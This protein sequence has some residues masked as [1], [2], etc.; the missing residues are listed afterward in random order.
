VAVGVKAGSH[1]HA[2]IMESKA[3]ALNM[4]GKGQQAMAFTFFKPA[5]R[6]NQT[7]SGEPF[8]WGSTGAPVLERTP[9]YVECRLVDTVEKGDH[10]VF[11]GE[12][13]G[14]WLWLVLRRDW[15][16]AA[17][18]LPVPLILT[19]VYIAVAPIGLLDLVSGYRAAITSQY[20]D[21]TELPGQSDLRL[22]LW[23]L[24]PEPSVNAVLSGLVLA[25]LLVPLVMAVVR[26]RAD[27]RDMELL[28]LSKPDA[29]SEALK[30]LNDFWGTYEIAGMALVDMQTWHWLYEH[31]QATPAQLK[32]AMLGIAR[33]VW[34]KYYA[35]VFKRRDVVLLAVYAH[36]INYPLYLPNY[37]LG[38]MIAFQIEEQMER[39]GRVGPEFERMATVGNIAPDLWMKKATGAPVG[40]DALLNATRK[41]LAALGPAAKD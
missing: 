1:A 41:A 12:A 9:A 14:R 6:E 24:W 15:R 25:G 40:P 32:D 35:P 34:N 20:G 23:H 16:R 10:S 18:A 37:P 33:E 22:W 29:Q 30:T 4:L 13:N 2:L 8:R 7:I 5:V 26:R 11:V 27:G 36:M 28:G 3:C 38:H 17:Y 19:A 21:P 39:A 31:P